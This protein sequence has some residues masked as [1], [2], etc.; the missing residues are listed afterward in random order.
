M[1]E[2]PLPG[3]IRVEVTGAVAVVSLA[4]PAK[5]NALNL[6]MIEA[7]KGLFG[8]PP[9]GVRAAVLR[10]DGDHFCA[11]LDLA[12][13][14]DQDA[15]AG[16]FHSRLWHRAFAAIESGDLPVVSVLRG[17]VIGGGLELAAATHIR[18]AEP[19]AFYALPE[20]QRGIFVGGGGSVRIPRLIGVAR[21]MD[22]MLTG[23]TYGAADGGA[24][25]LS[26]YVVEA[27]AGDALALE[28]AEKMAGNARMTNFAVLQALPAIAAA[29]PAIGYLTESLVSSIAA[30]DG[31]AK[32]RVA[33][34]LD[35]RAAK[36][37]HG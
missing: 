34:F 25:G 6:E 37:S 32:Q 11:G 28:L 13:I 9:A 21:M 27:G 30:S 2:V 33:E 8:Q 29:D 22:M 31:E 3:S 36:I 1:A 19:S 10:G 24:A 5:R 23:R 4:R 35:K 16:V 26:Q 20:G 17:A 18:V 14:G 15:T 12:D 7:L